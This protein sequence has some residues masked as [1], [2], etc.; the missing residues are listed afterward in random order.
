[1]RWNKGFFRIGLL[2]VMLIVI[3]A[4]VFFYQRQYC[5]AEQP[6]RYVPLQLRQV[7]TAD[8]KISRTIMWQT[9]T[10][11]VDCWVEYKVGGT[12]ELHKAA[13]QGTEFTT[14]AGVVYQQSVT[15]TDLE[16]ATF[17]EYRVGSGKE[18]SPWYQLKTDSG[19]AFSA[20]I[21]GDS[22]SLDYNVW[23]ATATAAY[24]DAKEDAAFFINMGDLVDN[25]EQYSQWR[26]WFRGADK[27]LTNIP[28]APLRGNHE[29]YSLQWQPYRG[30]LYLQLFDLPQNGPAGLKEQAYSYDYGDV[31][32]AVLDTQQEELAQWQPDLLTRQTQWLAADLAASNKKWKIVLMHR[33][34]FRYQDGRLNEIGA[35]FIPVI[36]SN[37]VDLVF[38][39]HN[40]S[41]S[42]SAPLKNGTAAGHGTVYFSTGRSGD[43]TWNGSRIK[44]QEVAFDGVLDQPNY[45]K[46]TVNGNKLA[47]TSLRQNGSLIDTLTLTK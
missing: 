41:Y 18:F 28:T 21:F 17:Y 15:L 35:A 27:L 40:H 13:A 16:P 7:I 39:G 2:V 12:N 47:V 38:S 23:Q 5:G 25:G 46:L 36:E 34:P 9:E 22:Q 19:G 30:D 31:H 14:D 45:L 3:G 20:L 42:R 44:P 26:S 32:F 1:M 4:G 37:N 10:A 43:K 24:K 8:S 6:A 29:N 11:A 33:T